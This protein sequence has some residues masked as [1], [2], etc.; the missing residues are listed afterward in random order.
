MA[1][2][3]DRCIAVVVFFL[4]CF[5]GPLFDMTVIGSYRL[6]ILETWIGPGKAT[7][8]SEANQIRGTGRD[9]KNDTDRPST[10]IRIVAG[11]G[12]DNKGRNRSRYVSW[13]L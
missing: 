10:I 1:E 6:G 11:T 7:H 8:Q 5:K 2:G 13:G 12:G 4:C 9:G 3:R